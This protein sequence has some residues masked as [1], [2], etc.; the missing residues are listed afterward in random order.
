MIADVI[1][2]AMVGM[3]FCRGVVSIEGIWRRIYPFGRHLS[4][5]AFHILLQIEVQNFLLSA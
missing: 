5:M 4:V 3:N 1:T 2:V